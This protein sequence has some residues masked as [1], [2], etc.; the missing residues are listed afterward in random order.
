MS[1]QKLERDVGARVT[2]IAFGRFFARPILRLGGEKGRGGRGRFVFKLKLGRNLMARERGRSQSFARPFDSRRGQRGRRE[3]RG[4]GR[5]RRPVPGNGRP[6]QK[7]VE[8]ETSE[9][10]LE[11]N[12]ENVVF[13]SRSRSKLQVDKIKEKDSQNCV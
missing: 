7:K 13:N 10:I 5:T 8:G 2:I 11:E 1:V 9:E 12:S 4:E 6:G 3:G